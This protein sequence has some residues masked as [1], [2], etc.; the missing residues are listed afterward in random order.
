VQRE[1][2]WHALATLGRE[3]VDLP[4]LCSRH[5]AARATMARARDTWSRAGG[6]SNLKRESHII[7]L[8]ANV[9]FEQ[10]FWLGLNIEQ[11]QSNCIGFALIWSKKHR[12][13]NHCKR[14]A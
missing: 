4:F 2:P 3:L 10:N 13:L 7:G 14:D 11:N 8:T 6:P 12:S 1:Q 5:C 9:D